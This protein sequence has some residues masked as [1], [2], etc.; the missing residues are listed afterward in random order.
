MNPKDKFMLVC[1]ELA[2]SEGANFVF[3]D[4]ETIGTF[5]RVML[6][7]PGKNNQRMNLVPE[8]QIMTP[9]SRDF[10][11]KLNPPKTI[12]HH[13]KQLDFLGKTILTRNFFVPESFILPETGGRILADVAVIKKINYKKDGEKTIILDISDIALLDGEV[14][15]EAKYRMRFGGEKGDFEIPNSGGKFVAFNKMG[16]GK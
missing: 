8:H 14:P 12:G 5:K 6:D 10:N 9:V 11:S 3:A 16:G 7:M 13:Y 2:N 4:F 15:K 1:Q